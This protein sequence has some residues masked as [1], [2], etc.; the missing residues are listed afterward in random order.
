[1]ERDKNN[2]KKIVVFPRKQSICPN[3]KK[4]M[5]VRFTPF[6][7]KKCSDL[8]LIKWLSDENYI[9]LDY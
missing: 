8:D 5:I 6:C 1:M 2:Q 3:C 4:K 9:N 7:S